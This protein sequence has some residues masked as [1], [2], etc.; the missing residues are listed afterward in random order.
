MRD[1]NFV[2][3]KLRSRVV[4][5][6]LDASSPRHTLPSLLWQCTRARAVACTRSHG[7]TQ[8]RAP[9]QPRSP[10]HLRQ[11]L[12]RPAH[13]R[14]PHPPR[15]M[16][17]SLSAP[18]HSHTRGRARAHACHSRRRVLTRLRTRAVDERLK[19]P[20][21]LRRRRRHPLRLHPAVGR[22][23]ARAVDHWVQRHD[24]AGECGR[25]R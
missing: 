17:V 6:R 18:A 24:R 5:S 7:R 11:R 1:Y 9:R 22:D 20:N 15:A 3:W 13:P 25:E 2:L 12:R 14:P 19:V 16:A 23:L 10:A 4:M 8:T 21:A